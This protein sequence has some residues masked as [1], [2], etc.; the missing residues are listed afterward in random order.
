MSRIGLITRQQAQTLIEAY[1]AYRLD[2]HHRVLQGLERCTPA[3]QYARERAEVGRIWQQLF[4]S[5]L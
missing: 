4:D 3:D 5:E 1:K 2:L